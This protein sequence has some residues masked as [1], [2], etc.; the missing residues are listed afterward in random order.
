MNNTTK[1]CI[2]C[3][4]EIPN[5]ADFCNFCGAKQAS[6]KNE[7]NETL[8]SNTESPITNETDS[9]AAA[10]SS[11]TPSAI[12]SAPV[13]ATSAKESDNDS[14]AGIIFL[15]WACAL[16][17]LF[18]PIIG[19]GGIGFSIALINGSKAKN[20]GIF[21]II[22]SVIFMWLGFTGFGSGFIGGLRGY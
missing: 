1:F 22:F 8:V 17:S 20:A 16:I 21:L 13:Q 4:K 3:G 15:G 12:K 9:Q 2:K 7:T 10:I 19:I 14:P 18:I 6:T 5:I 11:E